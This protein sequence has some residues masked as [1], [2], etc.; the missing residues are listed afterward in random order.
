MFTLPP[1]S[2]PAKTSP[3]VNPAPQVVEVRLVPTNK[4]SANMCL[5]VISSPPCA[6]GCKNTCGTHA[7]LGPIY[8]H[9][10]FQSNLVDSKIVS[11]GTNLWGQDHLVRNSG[12]QFDALG[13]ILRLAAGVLFRL[14]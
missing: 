10:S 6:A 7:H 14:T 3:S 12:K 1:L 2:T 4:A 8:D 11:C 9:E 13:W 5:M